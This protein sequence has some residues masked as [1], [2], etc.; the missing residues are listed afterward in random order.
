M[1]YRGLLGV[2]AEAEEG[3][4]S[5]L[6]WLRRSTEGVASWPSPRD[7]GRWPGRAEGSRVASGSKDPALPK[8]FVMGP[9]LLFFL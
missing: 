6:R 9:P 2:L 7:H 4:L 1:I 8:C 3:G 5:P